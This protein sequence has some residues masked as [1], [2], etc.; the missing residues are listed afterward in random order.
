MV[1]RDFCELLTR[2]VNIP[3]KSSGERVKYILGEGGNSGEKKEIQ[4]EF[5]SAP[6]SAHTHTHTHNKKTTKQQQINR[7]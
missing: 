6:P 3:N 7:N 5:H 1:A 2:Y 4:G